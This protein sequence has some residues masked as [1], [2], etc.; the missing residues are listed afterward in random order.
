MQRVVSLLLLANVGVTSIF[1][2]IASIL[3][4]PFDLDD[5]LDFIPLPLGSVNWDLLNPVLILLLSLPL[6]TGREE[7]RVDAAAGGAD[8]E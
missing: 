5:G 6:L 2:S 8:A 1:L 7:E 4:A 3:L